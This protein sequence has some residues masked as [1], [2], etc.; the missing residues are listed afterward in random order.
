MKILI[1]RLSSLGDI[2]LT[3]PLIEAIKKKDPDAKIDY[4]VKKEF[5]EILRGNPHL[6]RIIPFD[7]KGLDKGLSGLLSKIKDLR[8]EGYSHIIDIHN[9]PRSR[10][11]SGLIPGTIT[12][13]YNKQALKRRLLRWGFKVNTVHTIDAY[14]GALAPLGPPGIEEGDKCPRIYLEKKEKEKAEQLLKENGLDQAKVLLG[15]NA[16]AKWP[17]KMWPKERFIAVTKKTADELGAKVLIF[18]G[19]EESELSEDI[20]VEIGEAALSIAGKTSLKE[21]AA[22]IAKCTLFL[23]NDSGPMHM[24]TAVGV[25]VVALFGPTVQAFGFSPKGK[26]I[27]IEKELD[28][29]PCSLHGSIQCPK[30]HFECMN[31]ID[32]DTVF[33]ALKTLLVKH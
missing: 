12:L 8:K 2:I 26:S 20:A 7:S 25:P 22:L 14:L 32:V 29:R 30:G 3:T 1:I 33:E 13:R 31:L 21:S 11:I 23:S 27:V 24:A 10:I 19:P 15:I 16:G 4:L 18:G 17:T 28:C 6:N 5:A 9:T